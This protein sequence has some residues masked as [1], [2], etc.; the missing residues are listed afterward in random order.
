MYMNYDESPSISAYNLIS[1]IGGAI[2][3]LLGMSL[4][5]IFEIFEIVVISIFL[6]VKHK[7]KA[8][9]LKRNQDQSKQ[10]GSII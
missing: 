3:L 5:S 8:V 1:N 4:L 7:Y 2:G 10:K 6:I 9:K